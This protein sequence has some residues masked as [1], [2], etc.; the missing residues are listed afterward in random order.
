[1]RIGVVTTSYPRVPGEAA[2]SFVAAHVAA[3]R[4]EGHDVD[5]IGAHTIASSLFYGA[6]APDELERNRVRGYLAAARFSI[7][8]ATAP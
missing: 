4:A 6:G 8:L 2:G 1:M 5:V 3:L 7:E